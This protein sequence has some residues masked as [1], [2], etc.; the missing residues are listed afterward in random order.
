MFAKTDA[1]PAPLI[2]AN[3]GP[4][5]EVSF[6]ASMQSSSFLNALRRV[7]VLTLTSFVAAIAPAAPV[8][9][10]R[11]IRPILSD[12]CFGCHGPDSGHRKAGL[13]LD[14]REATLKPAKAASQPSSPA[15]PKKATCYSVSSA[16][17]PTRSCR[18]LRPKCSP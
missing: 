2:R 15:L 12:K 13:R 8:E 5:L 16:V 7:A 14:S 1:L 18:H 10:N 4:P 6:N 11:D 17:T 3:N 9:F